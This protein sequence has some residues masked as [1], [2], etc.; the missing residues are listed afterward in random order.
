MSDAQRKLPKIVLFATGGTIVSSGDDPTQMTGYSIKDFSVD[1]LM[2]SVPA[3]SR[4]AELEAHQ[5]ANIDS[6]SM[7]SSIWADLASAVQAAAERADVDGIVI[8][9]GT[10]TMDETAFFLNL[11]L[12]TDKPVV[13]TG[14]MR[15][16][17]AISAD[18]P[19]NLLNAVRTA[20]CPEARGKGVLVVLNDMIVAAREAQKVNTTNAAAFNGRDLGPIGMIAGDA[21]V[22]TGMS[23][24]PHTT[25]SEFSVKLFVDAVKAGRLPR[26]DILCAHVDDDGALARACAELGAEAIVYMGTGNGTVH[27]DAERALCETGLPVIRATRVPSGCVTPGLERWQ[28]QGFIPAGALTAQKARILAQ[29]ALLSPSGDP[30]ERLKAAFLKY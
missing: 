9:H 6:G 7:R 22:F 5:V 28:Q 30:V 20:A 17:T 4:A 24:K 2:S 16:A 14:A 19:L 21:I 11:V 13:M 25:Q 26:V 10:D 29:L 8:T 1:L 27:G 15:P 23:A 18:G 3:L 12:K